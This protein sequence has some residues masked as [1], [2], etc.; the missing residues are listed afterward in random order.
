MAGQN[1]TIVPPDESSR[2]GAPRK[3]GVPGCRPECDALYEHSWLAK[4]GCERGAS[5]AER[6]FGDDTIAA[7]EE[8]RRRALLSMGRDSRQQGRVLTGSQ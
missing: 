3:P 5:L 4:G 7:G 8:A 2:F 1:V 6:G